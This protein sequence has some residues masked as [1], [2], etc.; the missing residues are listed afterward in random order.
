MIKRVLPAVQIAV[1]L[2]ISTSLLSAQEVRTYQRGDQLIVE[3]DLISLSFGTE[4]GEKT[5]SLNYL[6]GSTYLAGVDVSVQMSGH[7]LTAF[8][9]CKLDKLGDGTAKVT[10]SYPQAKGTPIEVNYSV[11]ANSGYLTVEHRGGQFSTILSTDIHAL[12][13]PDHVGEDI[14]LYPDAN[15]NRLRLPGDAHYIMGMI[16]EQGKEAILSTAWLAAETQIYLENSARS[17]EIKADAFSSIIITPVAGER[18]IFGISHIPDIWHIVSEPLNKLDY[19]GIDW[20]PP[21]EAIWFVALQKEKGF[22]PLEDGHNDVW[23]IPKKVDQGDVVLRQLGIYMTKVETWQAWFS[24]GGTFAYPCYYND[25]KTFLRLPNFHAQPKTKYSESHKALIYPREAMPEQEI[26]L[27][28]EAAKKFLGKVTWKQLFLERDERSFGTVATCNSTQEIEK[29][30]FREEA[31]QK[32]ER[33]V[34]RLEAT[35]RFVIAIRQRLTE[36]LSWY[37]QFDAYLLEESSKNPELK[38]I[39]ESFRQNLEELETAYTNALERIKKPEDCIALADKII[40]L[41]DADLSAEDKEDTVK[42]LGRQIRDIG[43]GQDNLAGNFR[44][45]LKIVRRNATL[46]M[47]TVQDRKEDHLLSKIRQETTKIMRIWFAHEGK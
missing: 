39:I 14:V 33:I 8:S 1:F 30:F 44:I 7:K 6:N 10:V 21:T 16:G 3:N 35:N 12:V 19:I 42:S 18:F 31:A 29:I 38:E 20:L 5:I 37:K 36:Y 15:V 2:L 23:Y 25:E 46:G 13:I 41:I 45:L 22:I 17:G 24:G 47:L 28:S 40:E 34:E 32:R 9:D 26:E 43:G 27:P 4:T 11:M